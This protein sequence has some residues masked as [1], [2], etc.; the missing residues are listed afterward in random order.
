MSRIQF[1]RVSKR[2]D[3]ETLAV[4]ELSV[5]VEQ[6]EFLILVGPSGCGKTT[7]LRM[8][9]GLEEITSG[10]IFIGDKC[11][12]D[13]PPPQRDVAMVF[14]NYALYPHMS[15]GENISFPLAR[16]RVKKPE[17]AE[18]VRDVAR[19]LDIEQLLDRRPAQLSGGQRQRVAIGRALVRRPSAFLMDE[20]LSNLDAKLRVQMRA[21]LLALH[22]R[23]GI[24]TLYVTHDQTE[25]MTL[26][27]RVVVMKDGVVQQVDKPDQL[28]RHP[29]NVFVATFIG[30][31]SM[32]L[33][34][35]TLSDAKLRFG[36]HVISA[37]GWDA[38]GEVIAGFRPED[39]VLSSP[40]AEGALRGVVEITELLG[41]EI[42]AHLR[43]EGAAAERNAG[44]RVLVRL[45][46]DSRVAPGD[47]VGLQLDFARVRLF[48]PATGEARLTSVGQPVRPAD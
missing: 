8:A 32:N 14:Q 6:G 13:L 42:L 41:P 27:D 16:Q 34:A 10:D 36:A 20:P 12:T 38:A 30:S 2:F 44:G 24:T 25:A 5:T 4:D 22:R 23:L 39:A 48:D 28:Y 31:P 40:D 15:V 17:I 9:A 37:P 18:R 45:D 19:L 46:P 33:L 47:Q 3:A 7:A 21:E 29:Q 11:V 43:L 35:G 26:G 1:D